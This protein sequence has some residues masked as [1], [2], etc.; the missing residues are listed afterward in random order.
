MSTLLKKQ[1]DL[2]PRQPAGVVGA[3]ICSLSGASPPNSDQNAPDRGCP[4]RY[5]YYIKGTQPGSQGPLKQSILIDKSTKQ[6]A[7][8]NQTENT[9]MQ[10]HDVVKDMFSLYCLDCSHDNEK[11]AIVK[12]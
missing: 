6:P 2:W 9:E 3:T 11:P 1:P 5:E 12:L 4:T 8:P 10:E 7:Q